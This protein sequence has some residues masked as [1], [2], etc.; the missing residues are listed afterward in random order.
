[1]AEDGTVPLQNRVM[2]TGEIVADPGRGLMMGNRGC[3]HGPDRQLGTSRWRSRLWI[4]CV[5]DWK[6]VQR[7]PMPPGRWT[8]LFF[9]DEAT[10]LAAGH[11][12]CAYC[13]RPDYLDFAEAWRAARDLPGRPRA[14]EMDAVLHHERVGGLRRQVTRRVPAA[15][16][17]DGAMI[18][19]DG[20]TGLLV[21]GRL[22]PWSFGGYGPPAQV[23]MPGVVEVLTPPSTVAAIA[24]GYRPL[25]HPTALAL[26]GEVPP[27]LRAHG[28]ALPRPARAG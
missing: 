20:R 2:P 18:R 23:K 25:V 21:A 11:R 5:L 6:G 1:V 28:V 22:R 13:R 14:N 10:A 15:G 16:L 26:A 8:A 9:L 4:C 19:A 12:P 3:L 24:A 7:D 27:G 17:P